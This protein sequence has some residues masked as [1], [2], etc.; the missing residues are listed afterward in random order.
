MK[1]MQLLAVGMYVFLELFPSACYQK[2]LVEVKKKRKKENK[3]K[4]KT[5]ATFKN[6]HAIYRK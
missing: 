3:D 4:K 6:H 1:K 5:R 2:S